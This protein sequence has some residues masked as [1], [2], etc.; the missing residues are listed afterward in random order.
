MVPV[1]HDD[2]TA[3]VASGRENHCK[4]SV[5]PPQGEHRGRTEAGPWPCPRPFGR[6]VEPCDGGGCRCE[7]QRGTHRQG[8][9]CQRSSAR[10]VPLPTR[11]PGK[12]VGDRQQPGQQVER[13][14]EDRH[15]RPGGHPLAPRTL[16]IVLGIRNRIQP[17][18]LGRRSMPNHGVE[19]QLRLPDDNR[20]GTARFDP[21]GLRALALETPAVPCARQSARDTGVPMPRRVQRYQ[22]PETN[23]DTT[24]RKPLNV[25]WS[26]GSYLGR[27]AQRRGHA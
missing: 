18:W 26:S 7:W 14:H 20:G 17:P 3:H 10:W 6:G 27:K 25:S 22:S 4:V 9:A 19:N 12:V 1:Q 8:G 5:R 24:T 23:G 21:R 13:A 11:F 15:L 2:G 16:A